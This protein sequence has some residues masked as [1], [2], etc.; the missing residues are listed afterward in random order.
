MTPRKMC[1]EQLAHCEELFVA[2]SVGD[3]KVH[4]DLAVMQELRATHQTIPAFVGGMLKR[5][6]QGWVPDF[7]LAG[8][9]PPHQVS[10]FPHMVFNVQCVLSS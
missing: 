10:H 4:A 9:A 2:T 5:C 3:T 6:A 1:R 8:P 7:P